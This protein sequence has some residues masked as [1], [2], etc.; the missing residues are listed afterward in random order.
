MVLELRNPHSVLAALQTRPRDVVEIRL[1]SDRASGAWEK[2][3]HLA[4][5]HRIP[6]TRGVSRSS[7]GQGGGRR[8]RRSDSQQ[9]ERTGA[10]EATVKEHSGVSIETLFQGCADRADGRG[11]W[12]ALDC[13]QDPHNVGA[14]FRSAAFFGV[15]GVVVTR[16][17]SA[18]LNST[19][20]DIA[21]GGLEHAPF[22]MQG[23]LSRALDHAKE[24]GLWILG[25]SEH[26]KQDI[27]EVPRD[28]PWL[29]VL[30]NEEKG[31]RRLTLDKCDEVCKLSPRG[32]VT[33]LNVSVAAGILIA[34]LSGSVHP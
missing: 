2:V 20:H 11:L 28:R 6:V 32:A 5:Q 1:H 9:T 10:A 14:V 22:A 23:N 26:A 24:A 34:T 29:L 31:L 30:G 4:A 12:L 25:S 33:S 18:P 15:Q 21:A 16:D 19:V 8:S 7:G 17:R 3:V 27:S 13:L